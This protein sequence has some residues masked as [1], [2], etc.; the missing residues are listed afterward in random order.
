MTVKEMTEEVRQAPFAD[1][2]AGL[3]LLKELKQGGDIFMAMH[4]VREKM[5][6][7]RNVER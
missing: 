1:L 3:Q 7:L 5:Q 4:N 6:T 2:W